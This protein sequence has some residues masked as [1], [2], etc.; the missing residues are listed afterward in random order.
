MVKQWSLAVSTCVALAGCSSAPPRAPEPTGEWLPV[1]VPATPA[2]AMPAV[3]TPSASVL[4]LTQA[5]APSKPKFEVRMEDGDLSNSVKR[6]AR[7]AGYD[8]HWDVNH[9]VPVQ[10]AAKLDAPSFMGALGQMTKALGLAGYTLAHEVMGPREARVFDR[11]SFGL[12]ELLPEDGVVLTSLQR[13]GRSERFEVIWDAS[14]P[15]AQLDASVLPQR[16]AAPDFRTALAKTLT[17]LQQLGY[18]VK[19]QIYSDR[20]VRV[21]NQE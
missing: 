21:V 19:A 12:F 6:W 1:N 9:P 2:P 20:V 4:S 5:I 8:L 15:P 7:D 14:T 17:S 3:E 16:V 10:R 11:L 13:W 18:P